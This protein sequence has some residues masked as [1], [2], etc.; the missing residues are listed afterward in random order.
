MSDL[1]SLKE[2]AVSK[3]MDEA[4]LPV[5]LDYAASTPVDQ[6]VWEAMSSVANPEW[7]ANPD[8]VHRAGVR[9]R[10]AI[11]SIREEIREFYGLDNHVFVFTGGATESI[12]LAM[13][14]AR[15]PGLRKQ[16]ALR[17]D[18]KAVLESIECINDTDTALVDVKEDGKV[19][20]DSLREHV[21]TDPCLVSFCHVNNETGVAQ[22]IRAIKKIVAK[23]GGV[24]HVDSAQSFGKWPEIP[25]IEDADLVSISGHKFYGPKG[26]G[27][28]FIRKGLRDRYRA[29]LVGGNQEYG[30]RS[31]TLAT[32]QIVGLGAAVRV[33]KEELGKHWERAK[34]QKDMLV[35]ELSSI[36][37]FRLNGSQSFS[38]PFIL[39]ISFRDIDAEALLSRLSDFC[40]SRGSACNSG[41]IDP[42]H[43]LRGMGLSDDRVYGGFRVSQ[44]KQTT[45]EELRY[46]S[47]LIREYVRS[48][49]QIQLG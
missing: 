49:R 32:H 33:A 28:L 29:R 1:S 7:A 23:H 5:Y 34:E 14:G 19:S 18:H 6:R 31:G 2:N 40:M 44:G 8:S 48:F 25:G 17:T 35:R 10:D 26:A 16:L 21:G 46:L 20:L 12:N 22:D 30:L 11:E 42:S 24:V 41:S 3:D 36:E 45:V 9:V 39:N 4:S 38:S 15:I 27:G 37:G 43:V 47:L 13:L